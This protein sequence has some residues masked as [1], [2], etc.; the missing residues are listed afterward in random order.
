MSTMTSPMAAGCWDLDLATG[1]LAL[2]RH[3][4]TMFG[5]GED[6]AERLTESQWASRFHP[7]DLAGVRDSLAASL[8][9]GA[10]YAVRFRTVHQD[11]SVREV[12]GVGRPLQYGARNTR[13]VGWNFDV[14]STGDMA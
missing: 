10:P 3:S 12:L 7:D 8:M 2:C 4:R 6:S 5:L 11:G 1:M 14:R 13:F 9:Q